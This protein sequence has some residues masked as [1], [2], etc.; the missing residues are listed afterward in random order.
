VEDFYT[1]FS[2]QLDYARKEMP[3]I[4]PKYI[5]VGRK[6]PE[7]GGELVQRFGRYGLY[8]GCSNKPECSH[9]ERWVE[10]IGVVCPQ[11][12]GDLVE[13]KTKKGR[14]FYGCDNYPDCDFASWKKPMPTPCPS[15]GG[16]LV[17]A[18]KKHAK[19]SACTLEFER[20]ELKEKPEQV[21]V[22]EP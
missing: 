13:K 8:I 7:C 14:V 3:K 19:C 15:C 10:R 2:E 16:L 17:E 4:Q 12:G 20:K 1:P 18:N 22:T 5:P 21:Q 11:D 9:T 6:C